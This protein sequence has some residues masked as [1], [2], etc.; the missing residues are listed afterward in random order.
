MYPGTTFKWY[1]NSDIYQEQTPAVVDNSPLFMYVGSFDKGPEDLREVNNTK[2]NSLYGSYMSFDRHGQ[3]AIQAQQII[4]AGGRLLVK[5]VCAEDATLGNTVFVATV[6]K[7]EKQKTDEEGNLIYKTPEGDETTTSDGNTPVNVKTASIKWEAKSIKNAKTAKEVREE[8][9]KL[10]ADGVFPLIVIAEN[11]RGVSGKA[12]RLIPDYTTSK[13]LGVMF[14]TATVF[15]GASAVESVAITVNPAVVFNNT[16]YA[17]DEQRMDQI[18]GLV[19]TTVFEEYAA[20]IAEALDMDVDTVKTMDLVYGYTY[21]GETVA[22][23]SIDAEGINMNATYGV[24][25]KNGSNGEFGA[26]P[27]NSEAW[28]EAIRKVYAGE[29]ID[30]VWDVDQ[31]KISAIVDANFPQ[32]IKDAIANFVNFREDCIFF[33][34]FGLGIDSYVKLKNAYDK[35]TVRSRYIAD[36]MTSYDIKDPVTAKTITVTMMYD[37]AAVLVS[38]FASSV[39]APMA[40]SINGFIL[41][42]A[43]KGTISFTPIKTPSVNQKQAVDDLH[44]NY[45]IFEDDDCVVQSEYTSQDDRYTEL[46]YINNVAAIQEVARAVRTKC[47]RVRFSMQDGTSDLSS[48]AKAVEDVLSNFT[49]NFATLRFAYMQNPLK[50]AQKIFEADIVF[51]F[52]PFA[53]SEVFN[54]YA[55]NNNTL[56]ASSN[57]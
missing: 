42:S 10:K 9:L 31:H 1:D 18:N 55:V 51:A 33:R 30:S 49:G 45:A 3:G 53:Q 21:K 35:N 26:A 38:H 46:S 28:V 37:L 41:P 25:L 2:F 8:A 22:N 17:L 47:P 23:L 40:G 24:E 34:D 54:L 6:T 44:V 36:Y 13:N 43:I 11:G 48:Y 32:S 29:V 57:N 16:S 39:H 4:N 15:E 56:T 52:N 50:I 27:A 19:D 5:R 20:F 7:G 12:I 14:Y